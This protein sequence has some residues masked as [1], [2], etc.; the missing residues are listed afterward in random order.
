MSRWS[1][2]TQV[3]ECKYFGGDF[4]ENTNLAMEIM[5]KGPKYKALIENAKKK[6]KEVGDTEI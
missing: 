5:S 2:N 1:M 3:R 4:T 6:L